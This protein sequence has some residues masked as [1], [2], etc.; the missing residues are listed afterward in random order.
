MREE[1]GST[2]HFNECSEKN[3]YCKEVILQ[4]VEIPFCERVSK[5]L[6]Q[7]I[8][9]LQREETQKRMDL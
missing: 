6:F 7:I 1:G 8:Y 5:N 9:N 3:V 4:D 2:T